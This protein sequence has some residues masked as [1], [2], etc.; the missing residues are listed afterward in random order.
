MR[1]VVKYV[2][3]CKDPDDGDTW[4]A[5][6][7]TSRRAAERELARLVRNRIVKRRGKV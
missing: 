7:F 1:R 2:I 3:E 6:S 4:P 5:R